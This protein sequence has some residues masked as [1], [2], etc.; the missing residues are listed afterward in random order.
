MVNEAVLFSLN[1]TCR[2][3]P[4]S[5][6]TPLYEESPASWSICVKRLLKLLC[7]VDRVELLPLD[8]GVPLVVPAVRPS[9]CRISVAPVV[10]DEPIVRLLAAVEDAT[11]RLTALPLAVELERPERLCNAV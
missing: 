5:R 7:R 11:P 1:T 10:P 4:L 2:L 8:T 3:S 9:S 6:L